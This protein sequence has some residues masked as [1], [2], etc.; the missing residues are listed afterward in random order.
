MHIVASILLLKC[1]KCH[2][3]EFLDKKPRLF[4]S[5]VRVKDS[6]D[7]CQS[8]FKIEPSFYYGSMYVA[9]ALGVAVT[10]IIAALYYLVT[11]N[12]SVVRLF[13]LIV[14]VLLILNPYLNAWSKN[15]WANFFFSYDNK[16]AQ[17]KKTNDK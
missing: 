8:P 5:W 17:T 3:G 15:I 13:F 9:Y 14:G 6:C 2:K 16:L 7:N 4:W 1:P 11:S 10:G 12:F